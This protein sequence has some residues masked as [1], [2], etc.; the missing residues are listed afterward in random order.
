MGD[1]FN[2]DEPIDGQIGVEELF[3]PSVEQEEKVVDTKPIDGQ[4]SFDSYADFVAPTVELERK[5]K[6]ADSKQSTPDKTKAH[7][8]ETPMT[9][10]IV[11]KSKLHID[12]D[13]SLDNAKKSRDKAEFLPKNREVVPKSAKNGSKVDRIEPNHTEKQKTISSVESQQPADDKIDYDALLVDNKTKDDIKKVQG[14]S[15]KPKTLEALVNGGKKI[16]DNESQ[17]FKDIQSSDNKREDMKEDNKITPYSGS[18]KTIVDGMMYKTV[19]EVLHESMI[20]YSEHVILDRALP[21]VEDGLKPVQRRILYSMM[22]LGVTP[23]KPYRK[24]A[25]I[26]GDCMG[27]YHPHG[28]SSVYD[29]MVRLAQPFNTNGLLV[30]GHGNFGSVDGDR[31][32]A[33]RYTEARLTSL[34]LELLRDLEK[35]TV[36]WNLNFDDTLKEPD[37]LP[38]RYP[39]LL[40]NGCQGI[41]VGLATNIP[42]HNLGEVID[43]VVA[44][45]NNPKITLKEMMKIIKGPDFPTGGLML[46]NSEIEQAYQT[47]KGKI[48]IRAK[49]HLENSGDKTNIVITELPYQTNKVT[50][51]QKIAS[52]R[53][54]NKDLSCIS[55][56]RD[57][58]DRTGIRVIVRLKKEANVK[59]VIDIILKS[60][61][62]QVSFGVNMVAIADGKPKQLALLDIISYYVNYQREIIYRRSKFEL[63]QAKEREHILSGLL[64]AIKNINEVIKIIKSSKNTSEAKDKLKARFALSDRQ[65]QAILDMR[66][67]RLTSLEVNKLEEE[68]KQLQ[69]LIKKLNAI[70]ASTKMQLDIVKTEMLAIKKQ[71]RRDRMTSMSK[72]AHTICTASED[73]PTCT[74]VIVGYNALGNLK[75]IG[76]KYYNMAQ[77]E[78]NDNSSL[79]E[80]HSIL[81]NTYSDRT[82]LA[83]TDTGNCVKVPVSKL[84]ES[85]F[86]DKGIPADK[87]ATDIKSDEKIV[88]IFDLQDQEGDYIFV[89]TRG[90]VKRTNIKEYNLSKTCYQAIKLDDKDKVLAII[91]ARQEGEL[92]LMSEQG[93]VVV[94][95]KDDIPVQGR[96]S[97][98]VIGINL[99]T[100]DKLVGCGL[101]EKKTTAVILTDIGCIKRVDL[102]QIELSARNRK[103][104]KLLS[105]DGGKKVVLAE[106]GDNTTVIAKVDDEYYY[107]QSANVS[108]EPRL[109]KGKSIAKKKLNIK[110]TYIFRV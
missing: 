19:D 1:D 26:V 77:K 106:V 59:R 43:G 63:E 36:K 62:L 53:D 109:G 68:I 9:Q 37:I 91:D 107:K 20:P 33:M 87:I 28:D 78:F 51:M 76:K 29:A 15:K 17:L 100:S 85:R 24:S 66:L 41:A 110:T 48:Y 21:R 84:P 101:V 99:A 86:K 18:D 46:D 16:D 72:V 12:N 67:S 5:S 2:P 14:R 11:I 71:Y 75:A 79:G 57:E 69:E 47:G 23:D 7:K 83:F 10:D 45:I 92:A 93:M 95:S 25:R 64:I 60:T 42:P 105:A 89:T 80:V 55:E 50:I 54:D 94:I 39:N 31:A 32:A 22:E 34:A 65:A 73:K 56:I 8:S 74:E 35:D 82:V 96:I 58:S 6:P 108:I 102:S 40:V 27:K 103:G 97:K 13:S 98:G 90:M 49:M 44:Y 88:G 52:L 3:V 4:M 70:I 104:V 81:Y 30:D 61:D 38:G